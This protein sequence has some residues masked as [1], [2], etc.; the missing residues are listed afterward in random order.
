MKLLN[1]LSKYVI[2][3]FIMVLFVILYKYTTHLNSNVDML[4]TDSFS[5]RGYSR[6][7]HEYSDI[8]RRNANINDDEEDSFVGSTKLPWVWD[9]D[10]M[11]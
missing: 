3:F 9:M 5:G 6:G 10:V 11:V 8:T 7:H 1:G 4:Y 2:Y